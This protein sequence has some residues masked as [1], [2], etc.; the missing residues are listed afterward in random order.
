[1]TRQ[2]AGVLAEI[3]QNTANIRA[4]VKSLRQL[5]RDRWSNRS[6]AWSTRWP[7]ILVPRENSRRPARSRERWTSGGPGTVGVESGVHALE[8]PEG[9]V[10]SFLEVVATL[11]F[12]LV[13]LVFFLL[14]RDDLR[15]RIVM[16]AGGSR[17]ALTS[18]AVED[19]AQRI[20]RYVAIVGLLNGGFGLVMTAGL[21]ALQVPYA[22]LWGFLAGTLRSVIPYI[23]PWIGAVFPILMSLAA[24]EGW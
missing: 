16:L 4:K 15:D 20:G 19:I 14:G 7:G 13:L 12:A 17:L 11:A 1:M 8:R 21:L 3:P 10:G 23:G 5:G 6:F 24:F 9:V 18:K 22:L 2:V